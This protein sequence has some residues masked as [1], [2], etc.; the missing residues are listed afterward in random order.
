[1][2]GGKTAKDIRVHEYRQILIW[3]FRLGSAKLENHALDP[4]ELRRRAVALL[5][6]P[7]WVSV[8]DLRNHL[9]TDKTTG[10]TARQTGY[11]EI[12]YF[13]PFVRAFLFGNPQ[14]SEEPAIRLFRRT[15][16]ASATVAFNN[17]MTGPFSARFSIDR[18]NLYLFDTGVAVFAAEFSSDGKIIVEA[19]ISN[20]MTLGHAQTIL[21][22]LRRAYPPF[23]WRD[24]NG[25]DV[26]GLFPSAFIWGDRHGNGVC[27]NSPAPN[28]V[29]DAT[30]R[31][32]EP[33]PAG[34][35][36]YVLAPLLESR[37]VRLLQVV[38]ER[39]PL[40]LYLRV[41][42]PAAI[43]DDDWV[44]LGMCDEPSVNS[45]P[46]Y[47]QALI[48]RIRRDC[49]YDPHWITDNQGVVDPKRA[50]R[51]LFSGFGMMIVGG[52]DNSFF[53]DFLPKHFR[54]HYFQ[55]ALLAQFEHAALLTE[56]KLMA[57]AVGGNVEKAL[58]RVLDF[59]QKYWFV[60]VSNQI[61]AREMFALWRKHL[62]T[63]TLYKQVLEEARAVADYQEA[64]EARR[65]ADATTRLTVA[66]LLVAVPTLAT[67]F[68]G[69][70]VLVDENSELGA[71]K[72]WGH[73]GWMTVLWALGLAAAMI[74]SIFGLAVALTPKGGTR[75]PDLRYIIGLT[76][77]ALLVAGLL[78]PRPSEEKKPETYECRATSPSSSADATLKCEKSP[79]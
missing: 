5:R 44:R 66:A 7:E 4:L 3:P 35:W 55:M 73:D 8:G 24:Q 60:D 79:N 13:H 10:P 47:G 27:F 78:W 38:D 16:I 61:Q 51:F 33:P 37:D 52:N 45:G 67:G 30:E 32:L 75:R 39:I 64:R 26:A 6:G 36:R 14:P 56:S 71:L 46:P 21:E 1:M 12:A 15:G 62:N 50:S 18:L 40:M 20:Q 2:K 29:I 76:A 65:S 11:Q 22:R 48:E 58:K 25:D 28:D 54:R 42:D 19:G 34:H 77:A 17:D 49:Y 63:K 68:L 69:M 70:N 23:W 41:D 53:R 59:T 31:T 9:D 72:G 57:D 43:S 74:G